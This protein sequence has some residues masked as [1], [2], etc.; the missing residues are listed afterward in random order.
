[1]KHSF[2]PYVDLYPNH[3]KRCWNTMLASKLKVGYENS[4][5]IARKIVSLLKTALY[6]L[7]IQL[8]SCSFSLISRSKSRYVFFTSWNSIFII[9]ISATG[10]YILSKE[11][12]EPTKTKGRCSS[13]VYA[14]YLREHP[15][16][17]L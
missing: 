8:L 11:F 2:G 16:D 10:A 14:E 15:S 13:E 4:T 9:F 6:S 17:Q 5:N 12:G 7:Q 3:V 1:M